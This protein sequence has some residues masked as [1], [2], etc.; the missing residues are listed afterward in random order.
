MNP[1]ATLSPPEGATRPDRELEPE[2][3][4]VTR[5]GAAERNRRYGRALRWG[6]VGAVLLHLLVIRVSPLFVKFAQ[7][8]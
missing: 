8:V 6:I 4:T 1:S 5:P 2:P 7:S 3:G